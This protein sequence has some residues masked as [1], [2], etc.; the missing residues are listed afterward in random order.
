VQQN[1]LFALPRATLEEQQRIVAEW[2]A[3]DPAAAAIADT[4]AE[5]FCAAAYFVRYLDDGMFAKLCSAAHVRVS[6]SGPKARRRA[7]LLI[8]RQW[9]D[10]V[11]R[12]LLISLI[13]QC[14]NGPLPDAQT[15]AHLL[16]DELFAKAFQERR[17][18]MWIVCVRRYLDKAEPLQTWLERLDPVAPEHYALWLSIGRLTLRRIVYPELGRERAMLEAAAAVQPDLATELREKDRQSGALRQDVRRLQQDRRQL[19]ARARRAEQAAR[20]ML[21]QAR[22]EVE[23]AR[24]ALAAQRLAQE[25][26]LAEQARKHE[27]ELAALRA[28]LVGAREEFARSLAATVAHGPVDLLRGRTV[29]VDGPSADRELHRLLVESLGATVG[30][31]VIISAQAGFAAFDRQLRRLAL[32]RVLIKC[33]GLYRHKE[34][35]AGI[36]IS[37]FQVHMGDDAAFRASKVVCCGPSAGSLMAEYGAAAMALGWLFAGDPPPGAQVEIWSDCKTMLSRIR[38]PHPARRKQ[39]CITLDRTVRRLISL[40]TKR[41]CNVRLRWV[42]RDEVYAV[43][44]LCDETYRAQLWYHRPSRRPHVPLRAFLETVPGFAPAREGTA[45]VPSLPAL[46]TGVTGAR[47]PS[48]QRQGRL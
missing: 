47:A 10:A 46:P 29:T 15:Q 31:G 34:G 40:L 44:R 4:E 9:K 3:A 11:V 1:W 35:R 6:H 27:G 37:A 21:S 12:E 14:S 16:T 28:R 19:Q 42:P 43:D 8:M 24:R 36:A 2:L 41:G 30:A 13:P 33:D 17:H 20:T 45:T 48:R 25:R 26:E 5:W 7:T 32:E 39:G 18:I 38:R 23:G 22:G